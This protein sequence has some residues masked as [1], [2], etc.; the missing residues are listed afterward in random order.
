MR[1]FR[2]AR[3]FAMP[4]HTRTR[5]APCQRLLRCPDA[6]ARHIHSFFDV[7]T[8]ISW[9]CAT[10]E[11][12]VARRCWH[13][14][15]VA[16][17]RFLNPP[18][19]RAL[20]T[21]LEKWMKR[22]ARAHTHTHT[23]QDKGSAQPLREQE[24]RVPSIVR[25]PKAWVQCQPAYAPSWTHRPDARALQ[26]TSLLPWSNP[27]HHVVQ[28]PSSN[29]FVAVIPRGMCTS[30][31]QCVEWHDWWTGEVHTHQC[32]FLQQLPHG[33]E[34][35]RRWDNAT[36]EEEDQNTGLAT[37]LRTSVVAAVGSPEDTIL[38][39]NYRRLYRIQQPFH[40]SLGNVAVST[41]PVE[42]LFG[43]AFESAVTRL[44]IVHYSFPYIV[45]VGRPVALFTNSVSA[46]HAKHFGVWNL[47][48]RHPTLSLCTPPGARSPA[49]LRV[50]HATA[51]W[52]RD[53]QR[54]G[55][56]SYEHLCA[57]TNQGS[58][59]YWTCAA[60]TTLYT[61]HLPT[62]TTAIH[63]DFHALVAHDVGG[64]AVCQL[65]QVIGV[66]D[67]TDHAWY[68]YDLP[69]GKQLIRAFVHFRFRHTSLVFLPHQDAYRFTR[70]IGSSLHVHAVC[71][72]GATED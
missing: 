66:Y 49:H 2:V 13:H 17:S 26:P 61:L 28:L 40:P 27:T 25:R 67:H 6:I 15:I 21:W 63:R 38:Q 33:I 12:P 9:S 41:A 37:Y 57:D 5:A 72:C 48:S 56:W 18:D 47:R 8:L 70:R 64:L 54:S 24:L 30:Q 60:K 52:L 58:T 34:T 39:T 4:T 62:H 3:C 32:P 53:V 1:L 10:T 19:R 55:W 31:G 68:V 43:G 50:V 22:L 59:L 7:E 11:L 20:Y 36:P 45:A 23:H 44:R 35:D 69:T 16:D 46:G 65:W 71:G 14:A 29:E 51:P 42:M